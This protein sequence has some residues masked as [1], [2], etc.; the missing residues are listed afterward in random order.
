[1]CLGGMSGI[2]LQVLAH[3]SLR[4]ALPVWQ[5]PLDAPPCRAA[6]P[7]KK[8]GASIRVI[9]GQWLLNAPRRMLSPW[10]R[11]ACHG[12]LRGLG[13]CE[14][15][16]PAAGCQGCLVEP[17]WRLLGVRGGGGA[18]DSQEIPGDRLAPGGGGRSRRPRAA[19]GR[20]ERGVRRPVRPTDS[21][22]CEASLACSTCHVYVSED[23]LDLLPPPDEREDDMLDMAPLLQENSRLGCQIVLTPELEGA[24]FTLPKITRNFYVDG[25]VPKPH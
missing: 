5:P 17:S 6:T 10:S 13:R 2:A 16:V 23:H 14:C 4:T 21:G 8:K 22:A 18:S 25:H 24:E 7:K 9:T 1:M 12:R 19:R 11:D 3:P 15:W 20:G